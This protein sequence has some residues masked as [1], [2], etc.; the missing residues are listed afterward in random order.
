MPVLVMAESHIHYHPMMVCGI[1]GGI[2]VR[3][4]V[5]GANVPLTMTRNFG[6]DG[7]S[8]F[9]FLLVL[10]VLLAL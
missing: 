10:L 2:V 6:H 3:V 9:G 1:F 8:S 4:S 5:C 7:G